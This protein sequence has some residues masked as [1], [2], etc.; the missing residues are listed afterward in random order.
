MNSV[1]E[2]KHLTEYDFNDGSYSFVYYLFYKGVLVYIGQAYDVGAR[3]ATH[4]SNKKFD[5][6]KYQKVPI[7][8][9]DATE[10]REIR[11]YSPVYNICHSNRGNRYVRIEDEYIIRNKGVF[12]KCDVKE[13][14]SHLL[15]TQY[16]SKGKIEW[17]LYKLSGKFSEE[18]YYLKINGKYHQLHVKPEEKKVKKKRRKRSLDYRYTKL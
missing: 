7:S 18:T 9:I 3:C 15:V 8:E 2:F 13:T 6:V 4:R 12:P 16:N 11:E 1:E 17:K 5:Q 10:Q 14:G